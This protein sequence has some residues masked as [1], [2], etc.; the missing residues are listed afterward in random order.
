MNLMKELN[1]KTG[2]NQYMFLLQ[3][4]RSG[5]KVENVYFAPCQHYM[6]RTYDQLWLVIKM[7]SKGDW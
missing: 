5:L 3:L 2:N 1:V 7:A 4:F 6:P